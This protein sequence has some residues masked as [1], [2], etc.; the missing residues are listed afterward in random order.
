MKKILTSAI[1]LLLLIASSRATVSVSYTDRANVGFEVSNSDLLQTNLSATSPFPNAGAFQLYGVLG[2]PELNNGIFGALGGPGDQHV[3]QSATAGSGGGFQP[4]GQ[5]ILYTLDGGNLGQ[6]YDLIG[7]STYAGWDAFRGGQSYT[8]AYSTVFNV[9]TF[10]D[11]AT[12]YDDFHGGETEA[13]ITSNGSPLATNVSTIRFTFNGGLD[14]G[15]AGYR[16]L[17]VFGSSTSVPEPTSALLMITGTIA[18]LARRQRQSR[19]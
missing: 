16:E 3:Y 18:L 19:N 4:A 15:F 5:S 17:D 14:Q 2:V 12:V 11:I 9:S 1:S 7:I 8:V 6:G 13:K 10:I